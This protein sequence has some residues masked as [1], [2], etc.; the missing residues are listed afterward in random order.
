M[1]DFFGLPAANFGADFQSDAPLFDADFTT[2][3]FTSVNESTAHSASTNTGTVSP[4][5]LV[6]EPQ[7]SAPPS[8]AF[9]NLTSPSIFDSPDVNESFE[10][11]PMFNSGDADMGGDNWFSLFPNTNA[12]SDES[13]PNPSD[14]IIEQ[15]AY[16]VSS[17]AGRRRS[18]PG[19]S[20]QGARGTPGK[21][22]SISGVSSRK[23]DKPLPPILVEDPTDTV[24]M[25]RARNTLAARKS[26]QKK[27]QRFDELEKTIE[28]L[29]DEVTHW[30]NLALSTN[31]G[32]G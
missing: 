16:A 32:Q 4:K 13:P 25:K 17:D 8:T 29:R 31:P 7:A 5:D 28:E 11:S 2:P 22:S 12:E 26:R 3:Q 27:V 14:D 9:T 15:P 6:R 19:H 20:P 21:H 18:S 30:K 1:N 24:A 23:R 10:T